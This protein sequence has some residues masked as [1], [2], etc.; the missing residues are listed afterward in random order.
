MLPCMNI[1]ISAIKITLATLKY[2]VAF[3][4]L[5]VLFIVLYISIPVIVIPGNTIIFQLGL[6][7][8]SDYVLFIFISTL[9]SLLMLMHIFLFH[10]QRTYGAGAIGGGASMF[11]GIFAG[12]FAS[13][14]C[15]PCAI[16]FIGIFGSAG[17]AIIVSSYQ[18]Y[19]IAGAMLFVLLGIYYA[20]RKVM[21]YCKTCN[22]SKR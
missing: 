9:T 18:Y 20:S 1:V 22:L 12:M 21:G 5:S 16:G 3:I 7:T 6:Y 13:I 10:H 2:Q 4:I 11:S 15:V 17:S 19:F 8:I 14:T